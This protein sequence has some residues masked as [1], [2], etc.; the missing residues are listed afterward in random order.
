MNSNPRV[1][2]YKYLYAEFKKAKEQFS[3]GELDLN[4]RLSFFQRQIESSNSNEL[5]EN[6]KKT[7]E[8]IN[9][10]NITN[11]E[12]ENREEENAVES[13][14]NHPQWAKKLYRKIISMIHPDKTK[15]LLIPHLIS[16]YSEWYLI[17][18]ESYE[19]SDY[20]NL[21]MIADN[22]AITIE[23]DIV[24]E[25]IQKGI[26]DK[27]L[28]IHSVKNSLGYEWYHTSETKRDVYFKVILKQLGFKFTETEVQEVIKK[29]PPK[30]G[31]QERPTKGVLNR[32]RR[33]NVSNK[34]NPDS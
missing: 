29:R 10:D 25:N 9:K 16:L 13:K 8:S 27:K 1:L 6:F 24:N 31:S 12:S 30:R 23:E 22:L 17:T 26:N 14:A 3:E 19:S 4:Y 28:D 2:E 7:A 32:R 33:I 5:K 34:N 18:V 11:K 20:T 15:G 21:I